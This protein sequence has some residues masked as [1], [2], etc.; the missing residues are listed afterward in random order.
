MRERKYQETSFSVDNNLDINKRSVRGGVTTVGSQIVRTLLQILSTAVLGRILFPEDFG[1][2]AMVLAITNFAVMMG[3]L[4]LSAATIQQ[5]KIT[6][7]EVSNLFW[8][9]LAFGIIFTIIFMG[10]SPFIAYFYKDSRLVK[11]TILL[12]FSFFFSGCAVQHRALLSRNL[13]FVTISVIEVIS[14]ALSVSLAII[15]GFRGAG[16][17]ALVVMHLSNPIILAICFWIFTPWRPSMPDRQAK[18]IGKHLL[19][20]SHVTI[21]NIVN[22]FSRNA[23]NILIGKFLGSEMLGY[24]SRAYNL[25]MMP[26]RQIRTPLISVGMPAL[27]RLQDE[28][29]SYAHYYISLTTIIAFFS[30]PMALFLGAYSYELIYLILGKGWDEAAFVFKVLSIAAAVQPVVGTIGMVMLSSGKSKRFMKLGIFVGLFTVVS[31]IIGIPWGIKG[32]AISYVV[33]NLVSSFPQIIYAFH[34]TPIKI[35]SFFLEIAYPLIISLTAIGLIYYVFS[36]LFCLTD[37]ARM[38]I[39]LPFTIVLYLGL[40][41]ISKRGRKQLHLI[42]NGLAFLKIKGK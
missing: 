41:F 8:V 13:R 20:G 24:Y 29:E 1:L 22:Y 14:Y 34:G 16:Y 26:I 7:S 36:K 37:I 30:I 17:W 25:M 40:Y 42:V 27:S 39:S 35:K 28:P 11:V 4:G 2:I 31:F 6:H 12:S 33:L 32:V 3:E 19:F 21:H 18:S 23:D 9:N 10:L 5:K 38:L 15:F